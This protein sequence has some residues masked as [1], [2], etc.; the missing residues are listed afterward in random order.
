MERVK[1]GKK[2]ANVYSRLFILGLKQCAQI[3]GK[4]LRSATRLTSPV[5][6]E[7][8]RL[9]RPQI[10]AAHWSLLKVSLEF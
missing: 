1:R 2:A 10:N 8:F 3:A 9:L 5:L 7:A 4:P 6:H